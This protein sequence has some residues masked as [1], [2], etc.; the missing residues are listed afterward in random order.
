[1]SD[2]TD[3]QRADARAIFAGRTPDRSACHYC[4]GLHGFV[5]GLAP[6]RQPCPRVKRVA[7]HPNGV[8]ADVLFREPGTWEGRVVFPEDVYE[9]DEP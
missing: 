2:L 5:A 8:V 7:Y 1:M 3:Q 9:D 4:G 6:E